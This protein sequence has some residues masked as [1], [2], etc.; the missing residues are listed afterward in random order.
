M[1]LLVLTWISHLQSISHH[2]LLIYRIDYLNILLAIVLMS[3]TLWYIDV[4][5][6]SAGLEQQLGHIILRLK[7]VNLNVRSMLT[8]FSL[9]ICACRRLFQ[10]LFIQSNLT[11]FILNVVVFLQLQIKYSAANLT[12]HKNVFLAFSL[13]KCILHFHG[14]LAFVC[15]F[16]IFPQL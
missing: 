4:T 5:K 6:L 2:V 11:K 10:S 12:L 13:Q 9:S 15:G 3:F 7:L 1:L 14:F 16:S 8:V